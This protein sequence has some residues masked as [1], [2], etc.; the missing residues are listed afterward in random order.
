MNSFVV[1]DLVVLEPVDGGVQITFWLETTSTKFLARIT[2]INT[3]FL[4]TGEER[5]VGGKT[6]RGFKGYPAGSVEAR[7]TDLSDCPVVYPLGAFGRLG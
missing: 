3:V 1:P 2:N 6:L 7:T 5:V 4:A